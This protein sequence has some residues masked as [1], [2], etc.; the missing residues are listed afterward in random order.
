MAYTKRGR[1]VAI[2]DSNQID[3]SIL[4]FSIEK[5]YREDFERVWPKTFSTGFTVN[6]LVEGEGYL[7]ENG[8]KHSLVPNT[9]WIGFPN[10]SRC[11]KTDAEEPMLVSWFSLNGAKALT[12]LSRLGFTRE[13]P[14]LHLPPDN[15]IRQL[16][17]ETPEK[18]DA[19]PDFSDLIALSA[20]YQIF[21]LLSLNTHLQQEE[22]KK[23]V[24]ALHVA[25]AV[26]YINMHY[27][28]ADLSIAT[29][30][31]ALCISPKYLTN[32]FK[33]V[34]G[35]TFSRFLQNK[36]ISAANTLMEQ[37]KTNI[38]EIAYAVGFNS[39]YYFSTLYKKLNYDSPKKHLNLIQGKRRTPPPKK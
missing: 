4:G 2:F 9:L 24:Q 5:K 39:P 16:F 22:K 1:R 3:I 36:R 8:Q 31:Q 23:T 27:S 7:L 6:Y 35:V 17:T 34:M 19:Y 28:N 15:K 26:A 21:E 11:M 30:A 29:V 13:T 18:C 38:R 12:W 33:S 25:N 14:M 10:D 20:F 37:G 32:I